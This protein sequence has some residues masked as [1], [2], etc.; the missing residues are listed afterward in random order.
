MQTTQ[1]TGRLLVTGG[2]GLAGSN[3][4]LL[5]RQRGWDVRVLVRA[6]SSSTV[7]ADAGIETV[8]GDLGDPA[9]LAAAV[10]GM[11][12]VVHAAAS[13]AGTWSSA[14]PE[15]HDLVNRIGALNLLEALTGRGIQRVVWI[16][17]VS[18]LDSSFTLTERSPVIE[19]AAAASPYVASKRAAYYAAMYRAATDLP[20]S[21]VTPGCIYG[22]GPFV[23]RVMDPASFTSILQ[24]GIT[25][26]IDSY[27]TFP[28][29]WTYVADLAE[30]CIRVLDR[31]EDG[32]R[33]LSVGRDQDVSSLASFCN[34]GAVIAGSPH[35]VAEIDP[36][37][38]DGPDVGTMK[39]FALRT[40]ATPYIDERL[41]S[42]R[43]GY[44]P[45]PRHA[46]LTATVE[47]LRAE[48]LI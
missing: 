37:A 8:V 15:S 38:K 41:T 14:T 6:R 2:T 17:T 10:D 27:V 1:P 29:Y 30:I 34:E 39:Q 11:T 13:I 35:R 31:G 4:A 22:P 42:E 45:T 18:I 16:D 28:L 24:R 47:W 23:D 44:R 12:H 25:G 5:A 26:D 46:A 9:S 43:L 20:I 33:Y 32:A 7:F 40:Y 36:L 19:V 3:T 48:K 21:F